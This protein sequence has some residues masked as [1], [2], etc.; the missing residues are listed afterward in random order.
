M[1]VAF[2]KARRY[3]AL[4]SFPVF[5]VSLLVLVRGVGLGKRQLVPEPPESGQTLQPVQL[6]ALI[7]PLPR[8]RGADRGRTC[9][10]PITLHHMAAAP[11]DIFQYLM[12]CPHVKI[13]LSQLDRC[14]GQTCQAIARC[15]CMYKRWCHS[16][17]GCSNVSSS[18]GALMFLHKVLCRTKGGRRETLSAQSLMLTFFLF[19]LLLLKSWYGVYF[20]HTKEKKAFWILSVILYLLLA[21]VM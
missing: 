7:S 16:E 10:H 4:D 12:Q 2:E 5:P 14:T 17:Q 11:A 13:Q 6:H 9:V 21:L 1:W 15:A 18:T 3:A 8:D 20:L 19:N